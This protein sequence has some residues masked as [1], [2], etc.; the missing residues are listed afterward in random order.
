MYRF[1]KDFERD[2]IKIAPG[3][4][5]DRNLVIEKD[6]VSIFGSAIFKDIPLSVLEKYE[7]KKYKKLRTQVWSYWVGHTRRNWII[8]SFHKTQVY[9]NDYEYKNK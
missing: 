3:V 8:S 5:L 9:W 2:G 6:C 1:T 4:V 7:S